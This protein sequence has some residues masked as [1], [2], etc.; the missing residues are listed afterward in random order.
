MKYRDLAPAFKQLNLDVLDEFTI[1]SNPGTVELESLKCWRSIGV[2]RVSMGVQS[3]ND[4][5]L[6]KLGRIHTAQE[7]KES[8]D[9]IRKSGITNINLD[10]MFG[11]PDQTLEDLK[12]T[13]DEV[14]S[15]SPDHISAYSLKIEEDTPFE[16][17]LDKKELRLPSEEEDRAMYH[18]LINRLKQAGFQQYEISNFAR[19]DKACRH[20]LVYWKGAPYFA[21]GLAAHGYVNNCREGNYADFEAYRKAVEAGKKPV[22]TREFITEEEAAFEYIMLGLRLSQGVD[23]KAF[24]KRFSYKMQDK[25][26]DVIKTQVDKGL[27][28]LKDDHLTLTSYGLDV[29]NQVMADYLD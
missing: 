22:E 29:S 8:F 4:D 9:I 2:N 17:M 23:L 28:T 18:F 16:K 5:L 15:L 10:L 7:A 19:P 11:L 20:N 26:Q 1:E 27:V 21:A 14:L 24:E 25:F 13:L 12:E 6:K 3:M